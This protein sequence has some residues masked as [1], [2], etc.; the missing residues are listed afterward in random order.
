MNNELDKNQKQK[1]I[2]LRNGIE[3]LLLS[4]SSFVAKNFEQLTIVDYN[5]KIDEAVRELFLDEN[6]I[7]QLI[8]D[9]IIQILKSKINFYRYIDE[10]KEDKVNNRTLDYA[11]IRN[12]AHKNL[13]VARNLHIQD[14]EK[15]LK[16]MMNKEDLDYLKLCAKALEISAIKLNPL[17]AYEI[18]KLI[19]VKN[20]L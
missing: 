5:Y 20:S 7:R 10:L 18:L 1:E 12:L 13:G 17:F 4:G 14:A 15:L 3:D 2:E 19:K 8:E 9:Y 11:N 6:V 16:E